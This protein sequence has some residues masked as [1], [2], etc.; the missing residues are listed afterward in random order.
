MLTCY[1]QT[2]GQRRIVEGNP[3]TAPSRATQ[4]QGRTAPGVGS[5]NSGRDHLCIEDG[6]PLGA[7]A[8]G[9]GLWQRGDLLAPAP[10][11]AGGRRLGA[12]T[13][14]AAGSVGGGRRDRLVA[15]LAG[16]SECACKKGG[17]E[18]GPNP[19]D[20]GKPGT[21][22]HVVVDRRGIRLVSLLSGANRHDSMLF[23]RLL[24]AIPPIK[25][26]RG[27]RRKR[28]EK[29]HADKG[30]DIPRCRQFLHRRGIKCRIARKGV[31]RS[32]RL[33]RHRWVV[34]RTFAWLSKYRRLTIRY[35]RRADI[36]QAFLSL[37]C[38]LICS[39]FLGF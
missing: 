35:E 2:I 23:E 15:G 17:D 32:D 28:P 31:E 22:R 21:K 9:D 37:G 18:T 16:F 10:G 4:T 19:T 25:T 26:V 39:N 5:G 29:L 34:E 1:E 20:K 33:G 8:P 12:V 11:L 6:H 13:P 7:A 14:S 36:H 30:Y 38:A 24:D 27:G 3:A